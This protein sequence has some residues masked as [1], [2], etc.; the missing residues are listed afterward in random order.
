[1]GEACGMRGRPGTSSS[2]YENQQLVR[3]ARFLLIAAIRYN[4]RQPLGPLFGE[5]VEPRLH[6]IAISQARPIAPM[7]IARGEACREI[8]FANA[9]QDGLGDRKLDLVAGPIGA[10]RMVSRKRA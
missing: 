10:S 5:Q 4:P 2:P 3:L 8:A 9:G 7:H 6:L 1:M